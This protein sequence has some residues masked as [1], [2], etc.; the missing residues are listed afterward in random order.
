MRAVTLNYPMKR[1]GKRGDGATRQRDV[2]SMFFLW[3][4]M[5]IAFLASVIHLGSPLHAFN[6]LNRIGA[7]A[8][9]NDIASGSLFFAVG[10]I[11]WLVAFLGKMPARLGQVWSGI[12]MVLGLLF[13]LA[14]TR[15][16][17]IDTAP[18]WHNCY[19][20]SAFF[21]TVLLVGPL[22]A[23][24]LLRIADVPF[25]G[26]IFA[27]ISGLGLLATVAVVIM[28]SVSLGDIH[29]SVQQARALVPDYAGLQVTRVLLLA[30]GPGCWI[31]PLILQKQPRTASLLV[32][33]RLVTAG[34]LIGRGL[35]YGLHMTV[36]MAV[37]G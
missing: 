22:F 18:I 4:V 33:L 37:A 19:T 15:V 28:Q 7:S 16:Y 34:E 26:K 32:G 25:N 24:L 12:T 29:S 5:G 9:S 31:C 35:F 1:V 27:A 36:G 11:G 6:S 2:R 23:A 3:L 30:A 17:Q 20:T 14:M 10:G 21:L 8:Q 13:V